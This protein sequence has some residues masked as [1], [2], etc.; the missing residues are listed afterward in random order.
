MV[1]SAIFTDAPTEARG[2]IRRKQR[3]HDVKVLDH[4]Q[5]G[6]LASW[7]AILHLEGGQWPLSR[8]MS[9]ALPQLEAKEREQGIS[10]GDLVRERR[11]Q[12]G[13]PDEVADKFL[14]FRAGLAVAL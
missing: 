2:L 7:T 12:H 9:E 14:R 11:R 13:L 10:F 6:Y 3:G 1:Q 4:G 8:A 5:Y